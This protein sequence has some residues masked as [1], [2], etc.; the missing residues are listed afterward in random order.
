MN[1]CSTSKNIARHTFLGSKEE[2][3]MPVYVCHWWIFQQLTRTPNWL[4]C[5]ISNLSM[6]SLRQ[7]RSS[8]SDNQVIIGKSWLWSISGFGTIITPNTFHCSTAF[9]IRGTCDIKHLMYFVAV[10]SLIGGKFAHRIVFQ[11]TNLF[12]YVLCVS[13]QVCFVLQRCD[14][15]PVASLFTLFSDHITDYF[16]L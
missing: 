16:N 15:M 5:M 13:V 1:A 9:R 8:F 12:D 10:G 11:Y 6:N 3:M 7:F 2:F 14:L 4:D